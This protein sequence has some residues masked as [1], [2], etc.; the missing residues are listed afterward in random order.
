V[1]NKNLAMKNTIVLFFLI[2]FCSAFSCNQGGSLEDSTSNSKKLRNEIDAL[3]TKLRKAKLVPDEMP[4]AK[5]LVKKS[6]SYSEL[7]PQ[8]EKTAAVLFKAADVA[9]GIGEYGKAI[10]LWGKVW[11]TY[12]DFN[13]AP[14]AVFMQAFTY[15]NNLKDIQNAKRYYLQFIEKFPKNPLRE[16]AIIALKN[17]GKSPEDLIKEFQKNEKK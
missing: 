12:P 5:E 7:Y 10:Q 13:K 14:D 3:E 8:D 11:R 17:L 16:Q 9:R 4:A 2:F 6:Q 1:K 15:E